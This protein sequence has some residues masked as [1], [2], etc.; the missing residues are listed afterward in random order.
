M[1]INRPQL[2][3]CYLMLTMILIM[4]LVES[5]I[6]ES[7][8][9]CCFISRNSCWQASMLVNLT[10]M[11]R[12]GSQLHN[13]TQLDAVCTIDLGKIVKMYTDVTASAWSSIQE[14]AA[15]WL[16]LESFAACI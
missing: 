13:D 1:H 10:L 9:Q 3:S 15:T 14:C 7:I 16:C 12:A 2:F 5:C 8:V 4:H 11:D 6:V